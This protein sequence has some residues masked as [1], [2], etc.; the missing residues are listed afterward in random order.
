MSPVEARLIAQA[1]VIRI[2]MKALRGRPAL[3]RALQIAAL[4]AAHEYN[5]VLVMQELCKVLELRG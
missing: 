5:S 3:L 1:V 4:D 2:V